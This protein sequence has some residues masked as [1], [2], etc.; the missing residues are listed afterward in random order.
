MIGGLSLLEWFDAFDNCF[1]HNGNGIFIRLAWPD[2]D[3]YR[4]QDNLVIEMLKVIR[5]ELEK[6]VKP[7]KQ[8]KVEDG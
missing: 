5:L 1:Y 3:S 2:G 8:A 6:M 7:K 4:A